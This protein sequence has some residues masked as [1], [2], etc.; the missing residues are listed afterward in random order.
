M[1]TRENAMLTDNVTNNAQHDFEAL[2]LEVLA[3]TTELYKNT[4]IAH[5]I[6]NMVLLEL[7]V[8]S[9][10]EDNR[11]TLISKSIAKASE[12]YFSE[13]WMYCYRYAL[14]LLRREE[15]AQDVAQEAIASLF[16]TDKQVEY[17]RGWL[18]RTVFNQ[19]QSKISELK[20]ESS[21]EMADFADLAAEEEPTDEDTLHA[22][23]DP[24]EIRKYLS[25]EDYKAYCK[26]E[27][28]SNLK[29]Y[30]KAEKVSYQTAREH[31]HRVRHN[32]K[33]NYLKKQGWLGTP[34]ILSFRQMTNVKRFIRTLIE[35][36]EQNSLHKLNKYCPKGILQEVEDVLHNLKQASDW[37]ITML[38]NMKFEIYIFDFSDQ[39]RPA[40]FTILIKINQGNAI[41]ILT[42]RQLNMLGSLDQEII[43]VVP[44]ECG[45]CSLSMSEI[46]LMIR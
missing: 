13:L 14:K 1:Q 2:Q 11:S 25:V 18:K 38:T 43:D 27:A 3:A 44:V 42:C 23:L 24:M 9:P 26:I 40:M 39:L 35:H 8:E 45:K 19:A 16:K 29:A 37:G 31:K 46:M 28:Y 4:G 12:T 7:G 41:R 22:E 33:H 10:E 15:L 6:T 5:D 34:Q 21:L 20:R 36:A 17:I 30:A 32:L